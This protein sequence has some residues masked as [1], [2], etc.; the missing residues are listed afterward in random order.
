MMEND[1]YTD[2]LEFQ[3]E[4]NLEARD[5]FESEFDDDLFPLTTG[6][7]RAHLSRSQKCAGKCLYHLQQGGLQQQLDISSAE[8][9][10]LQG[11]VLALRVQELQLQRKVAL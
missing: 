10:E 5:A 9:R 3:E 4:A 6:S 2:D 8:L 7:G 11:Q 1:P